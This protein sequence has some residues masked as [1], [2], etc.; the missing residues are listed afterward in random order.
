MKK[1]KIA[2]LISLMLCAFGF[3]AAC[4]KGSELAAP[5]G[6][7]YNIENEL[8][9]SAVEDARAYYVQIIDVSTGKEV[10]GEGGKVRRTTTKYSLAKLPEGDYEI[11]VMAL[12]KNEELENEW[13]ETI[14]FHKNYESGCVYTLI[15]NDTEY[16]LTK[17]GSAPEQIE[18]ED[19]YRNKPVT[20]IG[21]RAFKGYSVIQDV[22][23]GDNVRVI[24]DNAFYGCK[25]LTKIELGE[26]VTEIGISA[27]Q[28]CTAL[29]E[30]IF[31]KAL[32][33][34]DDSAFAYCRA[35][36]NVDLPDAIAEIGT[37]AFLGC[38]ALTSIELPDS[39][40]TLGH[41]AF[42]ESPALKSVTIGAGLAEIPS[43]AFYK[44]EGLE[45][46]TFST[47]KT[48]K[49]I[50]NSAF[51]NCYALE[52][53]KIPEGVEH[54]AEYAFKM[55]IEYELAYDGTLY[56][57]YQSKLDE[58][59][60]PSTIISVG[61]EAFWG[62]KLY[63][64]V[65]TELKSLPFE[66]EEAEAPVDGEPKLEIEEREVPVA[67]TKKA[68]IY[69]DGWVVGATSPMMNKMEKIGKDSFDDA[70]TEVYGIADVAFK[71]AP[72]LE[73][74]YLPSS[75]RY[76]G[77]GAFQQISSLLYF[78]M[79]EDSKLE[80]I[81]QYAFANCTY[82][83]TVVLGNNVKTLE[84]GAF[85]GCA[86]LDEIDGNVLVP[87][88]VTSVGKSAF[89]YTK[90]M[91]SEGVNSKKT[92]GLYYAG[93]WLV[94][95]DA[96]SS[97]SSVLLRR[98]T[99]GIANYALAN[100][101]NLK[102]VLFDG[103][104]GAR[105]KYIGRGA[106][107]R[108]PL[109]EGLDFVGCLQLEEIGDY[110]FYACSKI[111][112]IEFPPIAGS[113]KRIG[114]AAFYNC[115]ELKALDLS[116]QNGLEYIGQS[117]FSGC[118]SMETLKFSEK[119]TA[120]TT[121]TFGAGAFYQ[122]LKLK[123]IVLPSSVKAIS[124]YAF[125]ACK[126]LTSITFGENVESIGDNAFAACDAL[127]DVTFNSNLKSIGDYA[128]YLCNG[129]ETVTFNE[130]LE[131]IGDYAFVDA[132]N[133][134]YLQLPSTLKS[135][136]NYAFAHTDAVRSVVLGDNLKTL[137]EHVFYGCDLTIYAEPDAR[138]E[139]WAKNWNSFFHPVVWGCDVSED[140]FSI[141]IM[142]NF[143]ENVWEDHEVTVPTK[144]GH[145]FIGW[146]TEPNGGA[147][148]TIE[149][150]HTAPVGTTLYAKWKKNS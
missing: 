17:Y 69:V 108:D 115:G 16:R 21:P 83:D 32:T 79:D 57:T 60:L 146:A 6:L 46:V 56:Y 40:T 81:G 73:E 123:E 31:K 43:L 68:F 104:N 125:I 28:S 76:I 7:D 1:F 95:F 12:S 18:I 129:L 119:P 59:D 38:N 135:I 41:S 137:G 97:P 101:S 102:K 10:E 130:G 61:A 128:F 143:V 126:S 78:E 67:T 15:N 84:E 113:L 63:M 91:S 106:F 139:G 53:I 20:E 134:Q 24:S 33:T 22:T 42:K 132:K 3:F 80:H 74:V 133:L 37:N 14:Y 54:I 48:L 116:K 145:T 77:G 144:A 118:A 110:A 44:C 127:K 47:E 13:S 27:F 36:N 87:D 55:Q 120:G 4:D 124:E 51:Y 136:G 52:E 85:G 82:L 148:Y 111:S 107:C 99:V 140:S 34:I 19:V 100:C 66:K 105:L 98:G 58:I 50:A 5:T 90:L 89:I 88:S 62:T 75:V 92:P 103:D 117:A 2:I 39:L 35:L 23:V 8:S 131:S 142:E 65:T 86:R 141:V 109:L 72:K 71:K 96:T 29:E 9:W 70:E 94:G 25:N 93:N 150:F 114:Q 147:V 121:L 112:S 64:D 149:N 30:I 45:T 49:T 122:C 11:R 26:S 138:P